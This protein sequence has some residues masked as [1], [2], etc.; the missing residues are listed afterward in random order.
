[1]C[2]AGKNSSLDITAATIDAA[3]QVQGQ[4][5]PTLCTD[6]LNG[7]DPTNYSRFQSDSVEDDPGVSP[8]LP[9]PNPPTNVNLLL[10][11]LDTSSA[12][13]AHAYTWW[14]AVGPQPPANWPPQSTCPADWPQAIPSVPDGASQIVSDIQNMC[15][16]H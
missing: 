12:A 10:G 1:M 11:A 9:I 5:T 8:A 16:V 3:Y 7:T 13:M 2:Y 15:V 4:T 6:A 14:G